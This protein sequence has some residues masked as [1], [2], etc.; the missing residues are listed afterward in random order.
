MGQTPS[1]KIARWVQAAG[2]TG[3]SQAVVDRVVTAGEFL[4]KT[5]RMSEREACSCLT[6][7]DFSRPVSV[8]RLPNSVYVQYVQQH[9]GVWFTDT[10]LTPDLVGLAEGRRTRKLFA[11]VGTVHALQSTARSIKD[12]WSADRLFQS[13]SPAARGKLGQMTRGGGT[14]YVVHDKFAMKEI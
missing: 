12:T 2:Q 10:G 7:I 13:M 1:D 3:K 11:P 5:A 4:E 14:Q 9:Q 8:V 6:G